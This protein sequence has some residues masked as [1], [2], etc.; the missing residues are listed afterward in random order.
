[1][2]RRQSRMT[3]VART[4]VPPPSPKLVDAWRANASGQLARQR[5]VAVSMSARV[6]T[7]PPA[8]SWSRHPRRACLHRPAFMEL[9]SPSAVAPYPLPR[10]EALEDP[11]RAVVLAQPAVDLDAERFASR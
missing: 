8:P 9:H 4:S 2:G 10:D 5:G 3:M 1:M 7:T 11:T 6:G